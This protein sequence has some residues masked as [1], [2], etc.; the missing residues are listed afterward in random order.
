MEDRYSQLSWV[1]EVVVMLSFGHVPG[2]SDIQIDALPNAAL[3]GDSCAVG[4]YGG[5]YDDD[6]VVIGY[7]LF[8]D[9]PGD[10]R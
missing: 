10:L 3:A 9:Q 8:Q 6:D 7:H 2:I 4:V 1:P 5:D